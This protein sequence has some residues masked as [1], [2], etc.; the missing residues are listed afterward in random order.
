MDAVAVEEAS[1]CWVVVEV[2]TRRRRRLFQSP[3]ERSEAN[4]NVISGG[5]GK[6]VVVGRSGDGRNSHPQELCGGPCAVH[7]GV[8]AGASAASDRT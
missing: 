4:R 6:R 7:S 5:Q 3:D 1:S 2:E 8:A